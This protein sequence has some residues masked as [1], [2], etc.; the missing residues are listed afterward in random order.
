MVIFAGSLATR[1]VGDPLPMLRHHRIG[2]PATRTINNP[3]SRQQCAS[4]F[5]YDETAT[6]LGQ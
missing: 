3:P 5:V 6:G 1:E 2:T 4:P